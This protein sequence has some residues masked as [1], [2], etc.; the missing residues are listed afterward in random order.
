MMSKYSTSFCCDEE[1]PAETLGSSTG[2]DAASSSFHVSDAEFDAILGRINKA[3]LA[4]GSAPWRPVKLHIH[5]RGL[6]PGIE[7]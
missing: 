5:G 2:S 1:P 6:C 4:Y 3:E 7:A